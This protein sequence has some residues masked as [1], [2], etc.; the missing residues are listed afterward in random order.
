MKRIL[1]AH[2]GSAVAAGVVEAAVALAAAYGAKIRLVRAVA[3]PAETPI[4]P[5]P[6]T[7]LPIAPVDLERIVAEARASLGEVAKSIPAA[8]S[9]GVSIEIGPPWRV[10]LAAAQSYGADLI[11]IGAHAHGALRRAIGTTAARI[12]EH[13]TTPVLVVRGR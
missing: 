8:Q 7:A 1:L 11:V 9:D 5:I 13:A 12:V 10:V 2:D 3:R 6:G 4:M